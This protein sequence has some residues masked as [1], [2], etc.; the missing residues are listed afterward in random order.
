MRERENELW[1]GNA[2][3]R[4]CGHTV[5]AEGE[6]NHLLVKRRQGDREVEG[7]W[8]RRCEVVWPQRDGVAA[9]GGRGCGGGERSGGRHGVAQEVM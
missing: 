9:G 8:R 5:A 3:A 4:V 2:R 7:E 6:D 1:R